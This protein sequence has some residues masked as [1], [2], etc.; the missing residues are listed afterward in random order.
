MDFFRTE[1]ITRGFLPKG[2]NLTNIANAKKKQ[3]K[4]EIAEGLLISK[5]YNNI[6]MYMTEFL[7]QMTI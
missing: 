5:T 1:T 7:R 2:D 3:D 4:S 6:N